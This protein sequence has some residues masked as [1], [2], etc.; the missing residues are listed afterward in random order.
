MIWDFVDFVKKIVINVVIHICW[1]LLYVLIDTIE[2]IINI[3]WI[4]KFCNWTFNNQLIFS[5]F[6]GLMFNI[7]IYK[8]YSKNPCNTKLGTSVYWM[9]SLG[10]TILLIII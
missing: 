9:I 10:Q 3:E 2:I 5:L 1:L 4:N 6:C 8:I 7:I